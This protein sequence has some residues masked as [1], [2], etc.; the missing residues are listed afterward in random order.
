M[1]ST[2]NACIANRAWLRQYSQHSLPIRW[3]LDS[4]LFHKGIEG[5]LA[6]P[7]QLGECG[8]AF[9]LTTLYVVGQANELLMLLVCERVVV[10]LSDENV[11]SVAQILGQALINGEEQ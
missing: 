10:A 9:G 7:R 8:G 1:W 3:C 4:E 5:G 2:E 6:E 11:Q